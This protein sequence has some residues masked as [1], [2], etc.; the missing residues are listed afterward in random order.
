V[1]AGSSAS[2]PTGTV[3]AL[4]QR[5]A[6]ALF[7][8]RPI[9]ARVVAIVIMLVGTA[10]I[11]NLPIQR[12]PTIAEPQ[13]GH[14]RHLSPGPLPRP[15]KTASLQIIEQKMKGLDGLKY[16]SASSD[17]LEARPALCSPSAPA[18]TST[19]PRSRSRTKYRQRSRLLPPRSP[20]PRPVRS[21]EPARNFLMA[22]SVYSDDPAV[23][24]S[25]IADYLASNVLD[26]VSRLPGV[27]ETVSFGTPHAMRI[28][29]AIPPSWRA[30]RSC[31]LT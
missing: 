31:R 7:T 3:A 12:Y 9:S 15:L 8:D 28:W 14:Q 29:L 27:G 30:L 20:S 2:A 6:A 4:S 19:S 18:P 13:I 22:G 5:H 23:T 26:P 11:F 21:Q 25:D 10:A 24:A 16:M 1:P 17:A